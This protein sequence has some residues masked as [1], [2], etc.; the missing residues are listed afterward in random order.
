MLSDRVKQKIGFIRLHKPIVEHNNSYECAAWWEE[1]TSEIGVF[2]VT[3]EKNYYDNEFRVCASIPAKVTNDYFPALWGGAAINDKP[4]TPKHIGEDRI[5]HYT[6]NL[7]QAIVATGRLQSS[8]VDW[9][10]DPD[11]WMDVI[12]FKEGVLER[13]YNDL[14]NDFWKQYKNDDQYHSRLGMIGYLGRTL[15]D[16]SKDIAEMYR[17]I[18]YLSEKSDMWRNLYIK[19]T[20][21]ILP[22]KE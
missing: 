3:L 18:G 4:Y 8:D 11:V 20:S 10:I 6:H 22:Y 13:A 9:Y 1:R 5:I 2:P 12:R 17:Q 14:S 19:N 21:W 16:A 15:S 7:V